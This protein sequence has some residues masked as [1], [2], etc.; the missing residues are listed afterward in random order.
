[1][2][3]LLDTHI[4]LWA[5]FETEKLTDRVREIVSR[6]DN[7]ILVSSVSFWEISIKVNT[8]KLRIGDTSPSLMP[9]ICERAG[10]DILNLNAKETSSFHQLIASYHKDPFDRML[11]W[12]ALC[13]KY[14]LISDDE[15][16]RKY[17]LDGLKII[18]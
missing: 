5:F 9:E 11:I 18:W 10:F 7:K 2:T 4:L 12:Q 3:Y 14:T 6:T 16:I 1:M 15:N 8:G 13:H 17:A